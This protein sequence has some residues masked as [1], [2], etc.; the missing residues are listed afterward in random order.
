MKKTLLINLII[1]FSLIALIE[2]TLRFMF[3]YNVQGISKNLI[4]KELNYRFNAPNLNYGKAFGAKIYTDENGYRID[5]NQ[6]KKKGQEIL[7]IGGSVTFGPGVKANNTFVELLNTASLYSVK[8]ASVFGTNFEN[9]I[10]II[11]S[12]KNNHKNIKKIFINFPL[13]DILSNKISL[14][15][16]NKS[17]K[18][19]D[20]IRKNSLIDI[21]NKFIRTKS[22]TYVFIK[23]I[24]VN[25]QLNNYIY[26]LNLYNNE[27]LLSQLEVNLQELS[28]TFD[29]EKI[30]FFSIPYAEQVKN[31]CDSQ[32]KSEKILKKIFDK[33]NYKI[34]FLKNDLCKDKNPVDFYFKNDPV[35]L[36][37]S[38]HYAV[39]TVLKKFIN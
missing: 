24:I 36:S 5:K 26:D 4:N 1:L 27:K 6:I 38:G 25:P 35:H 10:K 19:N 16:N 17:N 9:N 13:D 30:F 32:D 34:Y 3:S 23:S 37:K 22:A 14:N 7:F 29:R 18:I 21:I 11:E 28:N 31:G 12:Q 33:M 15:E 2:A 8:N 20:R 39:Y